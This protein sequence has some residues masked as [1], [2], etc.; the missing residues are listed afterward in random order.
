[1]SVLRNGDYQLL[2]KYV[3]VGHWGKYSAIGSD[4][5]RYEGTTRVHF[6]PYVVQSVYAR[7]LCM[8]QTQCQLASDVNVCA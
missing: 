4:G 6:H 3:A 2:A 1:M 5:G 7:T 8:T